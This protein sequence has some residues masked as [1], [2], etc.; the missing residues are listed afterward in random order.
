M[1]G[2]PF[3]SKL[4]AYED[5]IRELR[6]KRKSYQE[7]A[8]LLCKE[9]GISVSP[10]TIFN[11]VKVRSKPRKFYTMVQKA[12]PDYQ[13]SHALDPIEKLRRT[14]TAIAE[15]PRFTFD[16]TKPLTLVQK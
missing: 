7:I 9:H 16:E 12:F 11:F 6:R 15:K 5:L 4:E 1:Q 2:K 13:E 3:Q 10:S 14:T 8:D